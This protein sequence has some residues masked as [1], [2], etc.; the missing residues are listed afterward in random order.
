MKVTIVMPVSR[1]DYLRR[2]FAQLDMMPCNKEETN[3]LVYVD[4]D[5]QLY[6][7]ARTFT[8]ESKFKEKLC[9]YRRKGLP[10]VSHIKF[11]RMRIAEIHNEIRG[12]LNSGDYVM[13]LEDDTLIPLNTMEKLL[14]AYSLHPHA[15]VISGVQ[16]GRWGINTPG[17][18]RADN[19]YNIQKIESVLPN[20]EVPFEEIDASGLYCC[21][22][23]LEHY[24][25]INFEPFDSI[26]GP[27][28]SFGIALRKEG[29]KNYVDWTLNTSHLTKKGEIKVVL[30]DL[31]KVI[32]RRLEA[33][34]WEQEMV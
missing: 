31:Q 2:I 14:K 16:I 11:R 29:Y 7:T 4:G 21:M 28:V 30:A 23:K 19:P 24:K 10:N 32:F 6:Q 5:H 1:P 13:L 3:I 25:R 12:I 15:G 9:V 22:T 17:I 8:E 34:K 18:W 20:Q 33:E 26:L 27:D